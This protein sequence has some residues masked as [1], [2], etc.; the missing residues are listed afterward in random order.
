ML[1]MYE[2]NVNFLRFYKTS[3]K[4]SSL[5]GMV[6]FVILLIVLFPGCSIAGLGGKDGNSKNGRAAGKKA[7]PPA[8]KLTKHQQALLDGAR[9]RLGDVYDDSWYAEGYPP[10]GRSACVDIVYF[11]YKN[12]NIDLQTEV[13]SDIESNRQLYPAVGDN[14]INHRRCPNLI[15]W[16]GRYAKSLTIKT[17]KKNLPQWKPG[18]VVFWS[19]KNDGVA[20]HIGLISDQKTPEGVPLAIHQAA[21][22]CAEEDALNSWK[23]MGHF[24]L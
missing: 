24:R 7:S 1:I 13:N 4:S 19:M 23:I 8:V 22:V 18:D 17:D 5:S 12:I 14:A 2:E 3:V 16:F 6:F 9:S 10:A 11:A 21:P 20:D 15:V